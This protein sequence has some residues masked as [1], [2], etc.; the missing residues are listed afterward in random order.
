MQTVE[1]ISS[2]LELRDDESEL[3]LSTLKSYF[4]RQQQRMYCVSH[5]SR[6]N[7]YI[8][9]VNTNC[10]EISDIYFKHVFLLEI[11]KQHGFWIRNSV[12]FS[13]CAF[14]VFIISH[15]RVCIRTL[16]NVYYISILCSSSSHILYKFKPTVFC[17]TQRMFSIFNCFC[18]HCNIH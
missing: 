14:V 7:F 5:F 13:V 8:V 17:C 11:C 12:E 6:T 9:E 3:Y 1:N 10:Q 15:N 4:T 16:K 18:V 2:L